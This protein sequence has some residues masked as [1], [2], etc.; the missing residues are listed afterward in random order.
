[1]AL[2]DLEVFSQWAYSSMTEVVAQQVE[3]FNAATNGAITLTSKANTGDYSDVAYW[4]KL[5]GL[6]RRRDAYGSGAVS[7]LTLEQLL[8]TSVKIAAGTPPV[9]IE[10]GMMRW[11]QRS[12]EEAGAVYG[13]QLAGDRLQDMLNVAIGA[14][15]QAMLNVGA[16]VNYDGTGGDAT[17]SK[18]NSTAAL[19]GDRAQ[20]LQ[21]WVM[22]SKSLHDIYGT[23]LTNTERL[24]NF[25]S[26]QVV[27]DGFGRPLIMTDSPDL[28]NATPDP[29]EY[30][31]LGLVQGAAVVEDNM[32]FDS[33][34]ETSNG[35]ENILRTIQSEWS[36]NLGLRGYQWDKTNGGAS[37]TDAEIR[38]GTN[39]DK[40]STSIKD[41]AGVLL[42]AGGV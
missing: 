19:F 21:V 16:T 17:L 37:P 29:D 28:I 6:V 25:G 35:D 40:I 30:Y 18:L 4:K 8:A 39:W 42:T 9:E 14:S 22:H 33:N 34:I 23:A 38:T 3:L 24:F 5:S 2:T 15:V 10:P 12:P 1:M 31:T 32:D 41:T 11:I 7:A 27:S 20:A 26:V 36:Y 13:Q